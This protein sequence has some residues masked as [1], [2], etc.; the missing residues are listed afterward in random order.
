MGIS[1]L[2][3]YMCVHRKAHA[4]NWCNTNSISTYLRTIR[5]SP[6]AGESCDRRRRTPQPKSCVR[7]QL[8]LRR[9][10]PTKHMT[11][12]RI[13]SASPSSV[14]SVNRLDKC[15]D[16]CWRCSGTWC[17]TA[18]TSWLKN[19]TKSRDGAENIIQ[20]LICGWK[21][22]NRETRNMCT[23]LKKKNHI[24]TTK[25]FFLLNAL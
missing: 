3:G 20:T 24:N 10:E 16:L 18:N 5:T 11:T 8:K 4:I 1:Q 21:Q 2:L 17:D 15:A 7:Y 6:F 25:F 12:H 19:F 22:K 9:S 23:A 13:S 14:C